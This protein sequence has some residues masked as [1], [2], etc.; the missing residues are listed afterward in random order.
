MIELWNLITI[1]QL[2]LYVVRRLW[3]PAI[4]IWAIVGSAPHLVYVA[5][6]MLIVYGWLRIRAMM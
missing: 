2:L 4:V 1:M 5:I 3:I 6:G